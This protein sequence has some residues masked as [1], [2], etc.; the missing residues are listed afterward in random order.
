VKDQEDGQ[1]DQGQEDD[2]QPDGERCLAETGGNGAE[3]RGNASRMFTWG[4]WGLDDFGNRDG[5]EIIFLLVREEELMA[6]LLLRGCHE[7]FRFEGLSPII[8]NIAVEYGFLGGGLVALPWFV[9]HG[10]FLM[11]R[12]YAKR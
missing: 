4:G 5:G 6:W 11:W 7:V 2:C 10:V 8:T 9:N 3:E 12:R 1:P